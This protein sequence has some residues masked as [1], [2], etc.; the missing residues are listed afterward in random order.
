[1]TARQATRSTA[2]APLLYWLVL[3]AGLLSVHRMLEHGES[4]R[5]GAL[6]TGAVLGTVVGQLAV[7]RRIRVW[8]LAL[9]TPVLMFAAV[10]LS[11]VLT[12]M[13]GLDSHWTE[14]WKDLELGVMAF[15]PAVIC[16]YASLTERGGL[17]A[18]WF[19][20]SLWT[21]AIL[22][23][24][25]GPAFAGAG[26]WA[27][28][29]I[30]A[31][32]FVAFLFARESRRIAL[33]QTHATHRLSA[34]RET[35]VLR[36]PPGRVV[37]EAAWLAATVAATFALTA[38][39]APHLWQKEK[40]EP[41]GLALAQQQAA[42]GPAGSAPCCPESHDAQGGT[43]R[44]REYLPLLKAHA[45]DVHPAASDAC[46]ACREGVPVG[47]DPVALSSLAG[48]DAGGAGPAT[49]TP[50]GA[51]A[52]GGD[53]SQTRSRPVQDPTLA[54]PPPTTPVA[55]AAAPPALPHATPAVRRP[56]SPGPAAAV[57]N[58]AT[59]PPVRA[60]V[61]HPVQW[62]LALVASGLLVQL[63]LRPLRRLATLRHLRAPL[64]PE[65]VDQQVSN[66][67][68]L[69]LVGLRDA[70]WHAAPGEQPPELAR[71]VAVPG[72]EACALVLERTRHGVRL[73]A[74]DLEA[75][76]DGARSAYGAARRRVGLL[77][78]AL[79]WLRWPLV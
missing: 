7:W 28:L 79:S 54:P 37:A 6:W 78:R 77:A 38:W 2:I 55:P 52:S 57:A 14:P 8:V 10:Q 22:D 58:P 60:V 51:Q 31:A 65:P 48:G 17:A 72:A 11:V 33:W 4:T 41:E 74:A 47:P 73:D 67:W 45:D 30:L 24:A 3:V 68:Q 27:L 21:L 62:L 1:M 20:A 70:G 29:S 61:L 59:P 16:G 75:M 39:V 53:A 23:G 34:P 56:A 76:H 46:V 13:V 18:F 19:P 64:W 50:G 44:L 12:L 40:G 9:L 69:V 43:H 36:R 5:A 26:S 15:I 32:L 63:A 42:D 66:L 35:A 49:D 25:D 71:R